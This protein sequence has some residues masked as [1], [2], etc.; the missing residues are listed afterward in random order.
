MNYKLKKTDLHVWQL[1]V[2]AGKLCQ[3]LR[4]NRSMKSNP[5]YQN[6]TWRSTQITGI[7]HDPN[8]RALWMGRRWESQS[9]NPWCDNVAKKWDSCGVEKVVQTW[10]S[11]HLTWLHLGLQ[12]QDVLLPHPPMGLVPA[13]QNTQ[14][15]EVV[16]STTHLIVSLRQMCTISRLTYLYQL[17][18]TQAQVA[19]IMMM[20]EHTD[21]YLQDMEKHGCVVCSIT[22]LVEMIKLITLISADLRHHH[23]SLARCRET[24]LGIEKGQL[25]S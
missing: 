19:G 17:R 5:G 10:V 23:Q 8:G 3:I 16:H 2:R 7:D 1:Q 15:L 20:T 22:T 6:Y 24:Y 9:T 12:L 25:N 21:W 14:Q 11:S 4:S 13:P 18:S